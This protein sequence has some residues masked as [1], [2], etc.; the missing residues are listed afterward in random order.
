MKLILQNL[1]SGE[2]MVADSPVPGLTRNQVLICTRASLI[3]AGTEKMLVEFGQASLLAKARS[4]PDKVKQVLDKIRTDG[5]LPTLEAVFNKLDEPLPLGY[6][7]AGVVLEVGAGVSEFKPGDRVASNGPHAEIVAVSKTL[8]AKIPD[9][10]SDEQAAFTVLASIGLQGIRLAGPTLG[11]T[12]VVIGLGL[13]GLVTSQLLRAHGCRVLGTDVNPDRL[14]LAESFGVHAIN[15]GAGADPVV[16]AMAATEGKGVDGVLI[17]ASA[18]TDELVHQAALMCRKR[19]RIV[20]VGVVGL[21]LRRA[22]F[23]EKELSFQVSCSYGP[24]RYDS[25]YEQAAVDYP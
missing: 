16:A 2:T 11:E 7:N 10:V 4:Q 13:I 15:V 22:D 19:G 8:C 20:L 9:G 18:K 6:C 3:S 1:R 5:L 23:Y 17:T 25:Q 21:N 24:G 14:K 12:F